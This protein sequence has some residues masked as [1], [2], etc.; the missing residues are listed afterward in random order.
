VTALAEHRMTFEEWSRIVSDPTNTAYRQLTRLGGDVAKYLAWKKREAAPSTLAKYE[1]YLGTLCW[2]LAAHHGDPGTHDVTAAMLLEAA[3]LHPPD[4]YKVVRSAYRNFFEWA[5]DWCDLTRS[6]ARKLPRARPKR[7]QIYDIFTPT[8][9]AQLA[10]AADLMPAPWIQRL[11]IE[12][13]VDLGVRSSEG[14]LIQFR[15]VDLTNRVVLVQ[16]EGAKGDKPR[17]VPF[18]DGFYKAFMAFRNRPVPNVRMSD[19]TDQWREARPPIDTDYIFFP[20]G[21]HKASGAVTWADPFR[22]MADRTIRSWWDKV[23]GIAGVRYRSL[24]MNRHTFGTNL[25]DAG[26]GIET[27]GE[28]LGHAD[29]KTSMIYVHNSRTR[30]QRGRGALDDWRKAQGE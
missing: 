19:G 7:Q 21:F 29:P 11:R 28:F 25:S 27:I 26:A 4:S 6:P 23:T 18:G 12:V 5:E 15:D 2:H 8:E 30:L 1:L 20:Y 13:F 17:A 9:Q 22:P 16:E 14:R 24:H 10:K 3:D